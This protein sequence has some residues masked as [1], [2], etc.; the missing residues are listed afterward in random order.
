M[1]SIMLPHYVLP[2]YVLPYY[3]LL[4]HLHLKHAHC[5]KSLLIKK[6]IRYIGGSKDRLVDDSIPVVDEIEYC[7]MLRSGGK[8]AGSSKKRLQP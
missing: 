8:Q 5:S 3:M 1:R 4:L 6:G 2:H 7:V